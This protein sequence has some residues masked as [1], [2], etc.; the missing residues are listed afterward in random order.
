MRS[1]A[2]SHTTVLKGIVQRLYAN[3]IGGVIAPGGD[4]MDIV[5]LEEALLIEVRI[6]PADIAYIT[7]GQEARLKFTAYDFAIHGSLKGKVS[8]VSADTVTD[9]EGIS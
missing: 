4:I 9:E 1:F 2:L 5:P 8:F 7:V 3:T 6:K